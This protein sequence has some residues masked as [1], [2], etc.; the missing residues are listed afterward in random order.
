MPSTFDDDFSAPTLDPK[1][2]WVR[3]SPTMWSLTERPGYLRIHTERTD[4]WQYNNTAPLL[5]Q[6]MATGADFDVMTHVRTPA[7]PTLDY[8]Q[9]GLVIYG[10]DDSYVRLTYGHFGH[11]FGA[12]G[13]PD[14][15]EF[16]NEVFT[17]GVGVF[18][19]TTLWQT[20]GGDVWLKLA[21]Q[22]TSYRAYWGHNGVD[23]TEVVQQPT[24][25][26]S[27][28]PPAINLVMV[29]AVGLSAFNAHVGGPLTSIVFDF[30]EFR[31]ENL[32]APPPPV[33]RAVGFRSAAVIG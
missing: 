33:A 9:G 12:A 25:P 23:W 24:E 16:G 20:M 26:W 22:G 15:L 4:I 19:S 18:A 10:H 30:E 29:T 21:K 32:T 1:W 3:E 8:R 17:D 5:L 27:L 28:D 6:T 2:F 14:G 31:V 13:F 7:V 11:P